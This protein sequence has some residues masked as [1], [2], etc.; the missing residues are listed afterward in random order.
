MKHIR[1]IF[2]IPVALLF[3]ANSY[4]ASPVGC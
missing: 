1:I 3:S 2:F 4:S